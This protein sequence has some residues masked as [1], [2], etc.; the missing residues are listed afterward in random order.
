MIG[1]EI[2][3]SRPD[4]LPASAKV[5][6]GAVAPSIPSRIGWVPW[7]MF[8]A[9][10]KKKSFRSVWLY[11]SPKSSKIPSWLPAACLVGVVML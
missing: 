10:V 11:M 2:W 6:T 3:K 8:G 9:R 5:A 7:G 4:S 1:Y